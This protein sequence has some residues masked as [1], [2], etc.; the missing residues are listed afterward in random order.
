M[1]ILPK[2]V[3][4]E[5]S[6]IK[7]FAE[8][9]S[10]H[11]AI[12]PCLLFSQIFG[13]LPVYGLLDR[14]EKNLKFQW[15]SLRTFYAIV[16]LF[17]GGIDSG[18]GIRR[19]FRLGFNIK[20]AEALLFFISG[21]MKAAFVLNTARNWREIMMKFHELEKPF[22]HFPYERKSGLS[23]KLKVRLVFFT[24]VTVSISW[25]KFNLI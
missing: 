7:S 9:E 10:F 15:K 22:L 20:F 14:D 2:R 1:N 11:Q 16:F 23:L 17:F 25:W 6:K 5:K 12:G 18:T 24:N 21:I 19:F 3:D 8:N 4:K 13:M